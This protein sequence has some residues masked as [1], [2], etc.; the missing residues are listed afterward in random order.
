MVAPVTIYRTRVCPYCVMAARLLQGKGIEFE[1][2]YLD[3]A[4]DKRRELEAKTNWFTVP[5][6]F[7]GDRFIGGF[8]ELATI[9]RNG[10]LQRMLEAT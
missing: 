3:G 7:V 2:I 1:E 5:Q 9:D 8:T 4:H 6:V 10:E